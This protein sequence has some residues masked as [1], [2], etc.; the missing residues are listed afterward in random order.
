[1][2]IPKEDLYKLIDRLPDSEAP[3]AARYLQYLIELGEHPAA[4]ALLWAPDDDESL[5][6]EERAA[7]EEALIDSE[8]PV[9]HAEI[10]REFGL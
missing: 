10:R 5:T 2:A 9:E 8:P 3:A 7:I 1:M 6:D 4:R